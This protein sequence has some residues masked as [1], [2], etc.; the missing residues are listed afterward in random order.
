MAKAVGLDDYDALEKESDFNSKKFSSQSFKQH[1]VSIFENTSLAAMVDGT[2]NA[3]CGSVLK[4]YNLKKAS[5]LALL[6][7][8]TTEKFRIN[9]CNELLRTEIEVSINPLIT[10]IH[11]LYSF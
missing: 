7:E 10:I 8:H 4:A 5:V 1:F 6:Q 2:F 11:M 9:A 3:I